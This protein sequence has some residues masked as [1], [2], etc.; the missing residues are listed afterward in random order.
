MFQ[1]TPLTGC[2]AISPPGAAAWLR[3]GQAHLAPAMFREADQIFI[4][5]QVDRFLG[6]ESPVVHRREERLQPLPARSLSRDG[7]KKPPRLVTVYDNFRVH[8]P[9]RP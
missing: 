5:A 1:F 9:Q 6:A 2:A 7:C 8:C 3:V 4:P